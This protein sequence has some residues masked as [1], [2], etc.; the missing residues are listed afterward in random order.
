[1][2]R[3]KKSGKQS[4]YQE[5]QIV[6]KDGKTYK[7]AFGCLRRYEPCLCESEG[8]AVRRFEELGCTKGYGKK[9]GAFRRGKEA[10]ERIALKRKFK[11]DGTIR[12]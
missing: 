9:N 7:V 5:G 6:E 12:S 4:K 3:S 11:K 2:S 1:M 8:A 10:G